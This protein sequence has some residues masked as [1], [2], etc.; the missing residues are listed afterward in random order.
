[1]DL[2]ADILYYHHLK[3]DRIYALF[4]W[5]EFKRYLEVYDLKTGFDEVHNNY[6]HN[7]K[8]LNKNNKLLKELKEELKKIGFKYVRQ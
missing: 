8:R 6:M 2:H 3:D 7:S 4:N 1:M 5:H